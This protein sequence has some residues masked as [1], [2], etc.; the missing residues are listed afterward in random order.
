M[1]GTLPGLP[2]SVEQSAYRIVQESLTNAIK[3][4]GSKARVTVDVG[5]TEL[6]IDVENAGADGPKAQ[7]SGDTRLPGSGKGLVGMRERAAVF[8]GRLDA[9][10]LPGGGYRVRARLPLTPNALVPETHAGLP[11]AGATP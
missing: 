6:R 7:H 9:G 3:H 2:P 8:G 10:P 11:H 1:T 4:G 5:A